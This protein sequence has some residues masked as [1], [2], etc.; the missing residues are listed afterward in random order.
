MP[1]VTSPAAKDPLLANAL[2]AIENGME[3][4]ADGRPSRVSS[5]LR[6]LC[7]GVLLLL[8][9]KLRQLSSPGTNGALIYKKLVPSQL[10]GAVVIVTSAE[11]DVP[12][13]SARFAGTAF[14]WTSRTSTGCAA[15][16]TT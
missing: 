5:A 4:F 13:K 3:D 6:N 7:A 15:T 8:K 12:T 11:K 1:S 10:N 16:V 14:Q 9:E 2:E